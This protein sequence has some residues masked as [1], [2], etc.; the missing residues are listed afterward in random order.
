MYNLQI[1]LEQV[2]SIGGDVRYNTRKIIESI[3]KAQEKGAE[4]I[5]FPELCVS[6]Y[7]AD[8]FFLKD[9][10]LESCQQ[11]ISEIAR[12][13]NTQS[14]VLVGYPEQTSEGV[15][16]SVAI[17]SNGEIIANH[18]KIKIPSLELYE[19]HR[20]FIPGNQQTVID[21][22]GIKLGIII[23]EE[24]FDYQ[25]VPD[26]DVICCCAAFPWSRELGIERDQYLHSLAIEK[27]APIIYVNNVGI[28]NS[29]LLEGCSSITNETGKTLV[30][31]QYFEEDQLITSLNAIE[32]HEP[33]LYCKAQHYVKELYIALQYVI[34][35]FVV[36]TSQKKAL[37]LMDDS[38]NSK[39]LL[40]IAK[41]ALGKENVAGLYI[42][43]RWDEPQLKSNIEAFTK[44]LDVPLYNWQLENNLIH[45]FVSQAGHLADE[46]WTVETYARF[47]VA[48]F[49]SVADLIG[50]WPL[51]SVDK[52]QVALGLKDNISSFTL[53]EFMPLTDIYHTRLVELAEYINRLQGCEIFSESLLQQVQSAEI[54][55]PFINDGHPTKVQ[56][57][58]EI[59]LLYIEKNRSVKQILSDGY[60]ENTVISVIRRLHQ[61][62]WHRIHAGFSPKLSNRSFQ[63]D[64][65]FP[66]MVDWAN[67]DIR[68]L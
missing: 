9:Q 15:Y 58:D 54:C 51:S 46:N 42:R 41:E 40:Y 50:A 32:E 11:A 68:T 30:E 18:R 4:L 35:E 39:L 26:C 7:G 66:S 44:D 65:I 16:S 47:K 45:G 20:Y 5:I 55:K 1:G 19:E 43:A 23:S 3:H 53:T 38:I 25:S 63:N 27:Q 14:I 36:K 61:E 13:I 37:I 6:G 10:F 64:W 29:L 34:R 28:S 49:V 67:I 21:Y 22:K 48:I 24:L 12:S 62:E 31:L 2:I 33:D 59:L 17:M 52:T 56:I 8:D 60:D 57:M